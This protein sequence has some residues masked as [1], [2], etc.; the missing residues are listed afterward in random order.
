M[1]HDKGSNVSVVPDKY[2]LYARPT[3]LKLPSF[4]SDPLAVLEERRDGELLD[5]P[6]C[7]ASFDSAMLSVSSSLSK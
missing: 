4:L 3:E 2:W 5:L 1:L 6:A 7:G